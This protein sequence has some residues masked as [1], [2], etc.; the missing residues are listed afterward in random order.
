MPVIT[1]TAEFGLKDDNMGA[2]SEV[3]LFPVI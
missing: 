3:L 1:L 2:M